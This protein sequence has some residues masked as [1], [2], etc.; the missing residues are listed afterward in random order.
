MKSR[1]TGSS[2][3]PQLVVETTT[4]VPPTNTAP[5]TI[6]GTAQEGQVLS[7]DRGTW[8]GT[9]P[10][11]YA[12]QWQRCSSDYPDTVRADSPLVYWRLGETQGTTAADAS[13][14]GRNGTYGGGVTLGVSGPIVADQD[15]AIS[16]DGNNDFVI[17]N[18][19]TGFPS[20]ALTT[21]FWMKST[22]TSKA[23]GVISWAV[24]GSDNE[25]QVRDAFNNLL[26]YRPLSV[27]TN[28]RPNDGAWHQIAVTW[29]SMDGQVQVFKDGTLVYTGTLAPGT[30]MGQTGALVLGQDQDSVGGGFEPTQAY[31]GALDEVSVYPSVLSATRIAAPYS[32]ATVGHCVDI[33][34]ATAG[35]YLLVPAAVGKRLRVVVTASNSAGSSSA[36]SAQTAFVSDGTPPSPPASFHT[37]VVYGAYISTGWNPSTDNVGVATYRLYRDGTEVATTSG[38]TY[39]FSGLSCGQ[40]YTFGVEAYDAVGNSSSRTTLTAPS[41]P[42]PSGD[43]VIGAAGDIACVPPALFTATTCHQNLTSDL[44]VNQASARCSRSATISTRAGRCPNFSR[45]TTLAGVARSRSHIRQPAT[46][47]TT[48]RE[49]SDTSTTSTGQVSSPV[50]QATATRGTTPTISVPGI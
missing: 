43:P 15:K 37:A 14:N 30:T 29:R 49:P 48:R 50:Q 10:I 3:S 32:A 42:C 13:G 27:T 35:T 38:T 20:T 11:S 17:A 5:P 26:I 47:S 39:S 33:A 7:A 16:M 46:M 40:S 12:Y 44:L 34:G 19:L 8:T 23:A 21:E 18:P 31:L 25:F 4:D 9:Q 45:F 6:S 36:S 28:V 2:T 24:I 41:S 1:E 22:D